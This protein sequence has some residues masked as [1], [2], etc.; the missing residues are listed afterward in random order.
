[1]PLMLTLEL[2]NFKRV[3][4]GDPTQLVRLSLG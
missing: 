4:L 3:L 1:L 2:L